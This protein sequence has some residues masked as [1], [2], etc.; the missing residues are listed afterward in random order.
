MCPLLFSMQSLTCK[1]F[2]EYYLVSLRLQ[3]DNAFSHSH[4]LILTSVNAGHEKQTTKHHYFYT[5]STNVKGSYFILL[6]F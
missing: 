5:L 3:K 4:L 6:L 1:I 2:V